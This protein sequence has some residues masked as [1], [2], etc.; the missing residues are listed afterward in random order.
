MTFR[1]SVLATLTVCALALAG[2]NQDSNAANPSKGEK[3][4]GAVG[5]IAA[6]LTLPDG[7]EIDSVHYTISGPGMYSLDGDVPVGDSTILTFRIGG[8]PIGNGYTIS[9]DADTAYGNTCMGSAPFDIIDNGVSSVTVTLTCGATDD[10]GDLIVNGE[11]DSC[12]I[13]TAISAIPAEITLGHA[14]S[15]EAAISHGASPV[16]WSGTGGTFG[17]ADAYATSFSCVDAGT[18][19]LTVAVD[20]ADCHDAK[21]VDVTCTLGAGCG[22]GV[23][24][25][26]EQCDDGDTDDTNACTNACHLPACGD[27]IVSTGEQCDGGNSVPGDGCGA[28]C[29]N[30]VCGNG[31]SDPGETCDDGNTTANDGC[32]ATCHLEGCGDGAIQPG[33]DCDDSNNVTE[34]CPYGTMAGTCQICDSTC[35]TVNAPVPYCGDGTVNGGEACDDGNTNDSDACSNTC[36]AVDACS[37]CRATNCTNYQGFQNPV[38]GCFDSGPDG[39]AARAVF[40]VGQPGGHAAFTA[41]EV[42]TCVDAM[43]C[44]RSNHCGHT[45]GAIASDCYCGAFAGTWDL[46][47]CSTANAA[48]VA[49]HAPAC[50]PQ[51][52]AVTGQSVPADVLNAISDSEQTMAG[53]AYN[54][55]EC[56]ANFCPSCL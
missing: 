20:T 27:G 29:Q 7:S 45:L 39:A 52:A 34:S 9:L 13:I 40:G 5:S 56:E 38:A 47:A 50:Q 55:L 12:P 26:G 32:S 6:R 30:E 10:V 48:T 35:H 51:W 49:T 4:D 43:A 25:A 44:A 36:T 37:T 2:C 3:G 21:T 8:I 24:D 18:H 54:L 19:T 23:P 31:I 41:A 22:N 33:E 15:L 16:H 14:V 42:Q 11:V 53:Y 46:D 17:S 1:R 28:T